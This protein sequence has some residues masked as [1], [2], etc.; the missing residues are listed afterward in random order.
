MPPSTGQNWFSQGSQQY[1]DCRP[2]YPPALAQWLS[3]LALPLGEVVDVGCGTGQ[4][5][6]LL[7]DYFSPVIDVNPSAEQLRH[8]SLHPHIGYRQAPAEHLPYPIR[9]VP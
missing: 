4:L 2:D 8:A 7:A 9:A 1:A 5:T 3:Q 6:R